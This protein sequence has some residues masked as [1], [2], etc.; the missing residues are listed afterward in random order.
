[1]FHRTPTVLPPRLLAGRGFL[2]LGGQTTRA[3]NTAR[4]PSAKPIKMAR[5]LRLG[6]LHQHEVHFPVTALTVPLN[7]KQSQG[8]IFDSMK[9]NKGLF[10]HVAVDPAEL[11]R[12]QRRTPSDWVYH[13]VGCIYE[14][15]T[16]EMIGQTSSILLVAKC[17]GRIRI[18]NETYDRKGYWHM[19][20][21]L[22]EDALPKANAKKSPIETPGWA[23]VE[24]M[25]AADLTFGRPEAIDGYAGTQD[26]LEKSRMLLEM[27]HETWGLWEEIVGLLQGMYQAKSR[28]G[29]H[30]QYTDRLQQTLDTLKMPQG[31]GPEHGL[32]PIWPGRTEWQPS[33]D[34]SRF[35]LPNLTWHSFCVAHTV[36]ELLRSTPSRRQMML[37]TTDPLQR[38]RMVRDALVEAYPSLN[39]SHVTTI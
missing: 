27:R 21:Y 19:R 10:A 14:V 25:H 8:M 2:H 1:M 34:Q 12:R 13:R 35:T 38:L 28:D 7:D 30:R 23:N 4:T 36:T 17:L 26:S 37:E 29:S 9:Y 6:L 16:T 15:R 24:R 11:G 32:P 18:D 31:M 33:P 22:I 3:L 20:A 39:T 5:E